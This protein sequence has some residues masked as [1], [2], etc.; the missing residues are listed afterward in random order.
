M[1]GSQRRWDYHK[2][3]WYLTGQVNKDAVGSLIG[4]M[5]HFDSLAV[6]FW[7]PKDVVKG[8]G[9][10]SLWTQSDLQLNMWYS[11]VGKLNTLVRSTTKMYFFSEKALNTVVCLFRENI[12]QR[13][14]TSSSFNTDLQEKIKHEPADLS[15]GSQASI[16]MLIIF[17]FKHAQFSFYSSVSYL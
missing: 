14:A 4:H 13:T 1:E 5:K 2:H 17:H 10:K 16:W 11:I 6:N 15:P 7:F 12:Q 9:P 8:C 3:V